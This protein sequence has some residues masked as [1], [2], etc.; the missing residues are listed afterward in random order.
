MK[1]EDE[2]TPFRVAIGGVLREARKAARKNQT[3]VA[4]HIGLTQSVMSDIENGTG[5][6]EAW[7]VFQLDRFFRLPMGELGQ[8]M[9]AAIKRV[10]ASTGVK[11][12]SLPY[13]RSRARGRH[14]LKDS[15]DPPKQPTP[16]A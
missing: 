4:A 13:P 1:A 8:R 16:K 12:N 2:F 9:D 3:Q 6:I 5:F 15:P 10:E 11:L 7:T 14:V